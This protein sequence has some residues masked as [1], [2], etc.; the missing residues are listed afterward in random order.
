M[1]KVLPF[2]LFLVTL[3]V[4]ATAQSP[5][6]LIIDEQEFSMRGLPLEVYLQQHEEH[7]DFRSCGVELTSN[8]RGY[9]GT[10]K[11]DQ[12]RLY[13]IKLDEMCD[14]NKNDGKAWGFEKRPINLSLLFPDAADK[15]F[16]KWYS[17]ILR[18]T[19][20]EMLEY[21]HMGFESIYEEEMAFL[22][23]DGEIKKSITVTYNE[24]K[25]DNHSFQDL[26]WVKL[27]ERKIES[28]DFIDA[29]LY[30]TEHFKKYKY[31]F[32]S[33]KT[34][35]VLYKRDEETRAV[36]SIP[37]TPD[38]KK[39]HYIELELD[40]SAD[41]IKDGSHVE[42]LVKYESQEKPIDEWLLTVKKVRK[43]EF[44]ESIHHPEYPHIIN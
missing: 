20:G 35:G 17:G 22:V 42:V 5:E 38:N 4:F 14:V 44:G 41:E 43:L 33:F 15:V 36:L 16:A 18:V 29:R 13:L 21:V 12:Q 40:V 3:Q 39:R 32:E 7:P 23:K 1:K 26:I 37:S 6:T 28:K 2:I 10:W 31:S 27:G 34:R 11:V 8:W 9:Y 19:K 30:K 24:A 25:A